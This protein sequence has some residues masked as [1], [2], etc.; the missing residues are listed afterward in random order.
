[1]LI[2]GVV[3]FFFDQASHPPV[4]VPTAIDDRAGVPR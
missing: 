3:A 2:A 1:M 4:G